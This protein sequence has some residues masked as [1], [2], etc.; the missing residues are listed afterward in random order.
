M[1]TIETENSIPTSLGAIKK[2]K[3]SVA[4]NLSFFF[5]GLGQVY[6]GCLKRGIGHMCIVV[7]V[8]FAAIL[9]LATQSAGPVPVCIV[10]GTLALIVTFYSAY[11]ARQL[12]RQTRPDYRLKDYNSVAVYLAIS[13]L[14]MGVA[15]G[16]AI[17]LRENFLQVFVMAGDS[18]SPTFKEGSRIMVRKD[19]YRDQDPQRNDLVAFRNPANRRQTWV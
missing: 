7:A 18:M 1:K 4:T 16:F 11:D 8:L 12:A 9:V 14:F 3:P 5:A 13:F 17:A 10:V 15:G 2:R 19:V 6:C